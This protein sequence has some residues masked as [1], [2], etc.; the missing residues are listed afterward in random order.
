[1]ADLSLLAGNKN[2]L[3]KNVRTFSLGVDNEKFDESY[4]SKSSHC[5]N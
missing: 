3:N 4:K 5:K 2:E 1:M